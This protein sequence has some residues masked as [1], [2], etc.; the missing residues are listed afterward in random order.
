MNY[1]LEII[2]SLIFFF[3]GGVHISWSLGLKW[4]YEQVIPKKEKGENLFTP[5]K[6]ECIVMAII[7][8]LFGIFYLIKT[9]FISLNIHQCVLTY[10]GWFISI[11]FII[12]TIGDFKYVG[13]FK[14]IKTT[15]F[16]KWDNK[17]YIPL[18]IIIFII[19][20]TIELKC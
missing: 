20:I 6:P 17:L 12:R 9:D 15:D 5:R 8:F 11:L 4:G 13:I 2:L 10:S 1:I 16:A 14:S 19:S 3:I 7:F 18:C